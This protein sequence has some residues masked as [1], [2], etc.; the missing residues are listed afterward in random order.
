M[1][2]AGVNLPDQA[3]DELR[4]WIG[5]QLPD[6][7]AMKVSRGME[8]DEF[9]DYNIEYE[10]AFSP[11]SLDCMSI[12]ISHTSDGHWGVGIEP[13]ARVLSRLGRASSVQ[14][15]SGGFEPCVD[16]F[17]GIVAILNAVRGGELAVGFSRAPV[18]GL[19]GVS[20]MAEKQSYGALSCLG[21]GVWLRGTGKKSPWE[22]RVSY[23]PWSRPNPAS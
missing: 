16:D 12:I 7:V 22:T 14:R 5:D 1:L 6:D 15:Y 3:P 9:D 2:V 17:G 23:R 11:L 18:L 8:Q 13:I 20:V 4:S 19:I 21:D 10:I